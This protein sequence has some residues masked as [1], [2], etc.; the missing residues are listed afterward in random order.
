MA[1]LSAPITVLQGCDTQNFV[2][3]LQNIY[4]NSQTIYNLASKNILCPTNNVVN[5]VY[6]N[7]KFSFI[8]FFENTVEL[9]YG[10]SNEYNPNYGPVFIESEL[11]QFIIDAF[12]SWQPDFQKNGIYVEYDS[13]LLK[14]NVTVKGCNYLK[15][16]PQIKLNPT[17]NYKCN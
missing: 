8:D 3:S 6:W 5:I 1:T 10:P 7:I 9:N 14:V 11:Y 15:S 2:I 17:L 12:N 16:T 4:G 13:N